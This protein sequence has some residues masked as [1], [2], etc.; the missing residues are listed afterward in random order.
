MITSRYLFYRRAILLESD[1]GSFH[2]LAN[3][4]LFFD[5]LTADIRL[6]LT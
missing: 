6:F 3:L 2:Y 1:L 4:I 5:I